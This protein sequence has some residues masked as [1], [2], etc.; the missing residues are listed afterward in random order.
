MTQSDHENLKLF[1]GGILTTNTGICRI[2]RGGEQRKIKGIARSTLIKVCRAVLLAA[3]FVSPLKRRR[4]WNFS[5]RMEFWNCEWQAR[6]RE[7]CCGRGWPIFWCLPFR[8]RNLCLLQNWDS[9]KC[10]RYC[11]C[12]R[13]IGNFIDQWSFFYITC[14]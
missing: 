3:Q 6:T 12:L 7:G 2:S 11:Q 13:F 14:S 4:G 5:F 9:F 1:E 8:G 10:R